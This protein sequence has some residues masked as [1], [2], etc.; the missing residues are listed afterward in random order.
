MA[1]AVLGTTLPRPTPGAGGGGSRSPALFFQNWDYRPR[2]IS[3]GGSVWP[4]ARHTAVA[5]ETLTE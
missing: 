5:C 1:A 2:P 3:P 4:S